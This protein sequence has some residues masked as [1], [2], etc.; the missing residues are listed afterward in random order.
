MREGRSKSGKSRVIESRVESLTSYLLCEH[1]G[2][3]LREE[4]CQCFRGNLHLGQVLPDDS[5]DAS[6]GGLVEELFPPVQPLEVRLWLL[7][8]REGR[9]E[10][11][12][13]HAYHIKELP[14]T[15]VYI[16]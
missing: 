4:V 14:A 8:W 5:S 10:E 3:A 12:Y 6:V 7:A 11:V 16:L 2:L 13:I 1:S 15:R 9:G